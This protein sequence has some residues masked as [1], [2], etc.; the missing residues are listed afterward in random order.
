MPDSGVR[1]YRRDPEGSLDAFEGP[2][3]LLDLDAQLP[4]SAVNTGYSKDGGTLWV[5]EKDD[6]FAYIVY[7]DHVEAWPRDREQHMCA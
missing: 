3:P 5:D 6:S 4:P 1:S 7:D 2:D